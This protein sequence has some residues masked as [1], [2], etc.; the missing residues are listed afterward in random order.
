MVS[1]AMKEILHMVDKA[2]C[3]REEV[4]QFWLSSTDIHTLKGLLWKGVE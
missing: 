3:I 2:R 1:M 4:F